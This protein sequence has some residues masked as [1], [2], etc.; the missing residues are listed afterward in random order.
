VKVFPAKIQQDSDTY[1]SRY[2]QVF[3]PKYLFIVAH[4]CT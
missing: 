1:S 3:L 2:L 4:S